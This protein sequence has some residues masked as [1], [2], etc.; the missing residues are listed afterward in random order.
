MLLK[1]Q[2]GEKLL[3]FDILLHILCLLILHI[4]EP[5]ELHY[6]LFQVLLF[7]LTHGQLLG[8]VLTLICKVAHGLGW[9]FTGWAL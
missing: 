5:D 9:V 3:V 6:L 2:L 1:D 8:S 7:Y 4:A